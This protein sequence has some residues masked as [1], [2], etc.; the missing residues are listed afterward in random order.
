MFIRLIPLEKAL[1]KAKEALKHQ[2]K[3]I[4]YLKSLLMG[5]N[6]VSYLYTLFL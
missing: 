6:E 1:G 2:E 4:N 3:V 5:A